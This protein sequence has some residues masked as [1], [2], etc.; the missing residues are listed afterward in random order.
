MKQDT[1][2]CP[3]LQVP[4]AKNLFLH[5]KSE[6]IQILEIPLE[7][8]LNKPKA[9]RAGTSSLLLNYIGG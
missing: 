2:Q 7:K 1:T 4:Y 8:K 9:K 5:L 6:C 3:T